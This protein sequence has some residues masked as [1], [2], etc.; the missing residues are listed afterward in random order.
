MFKCGLTLVVGSLVLPSVA[1]WMCV[2]LC[3][4]FAICWLVRA[5]RGAQQHGRQRIAVGCSNRYDTMQMVS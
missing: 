5:R 1:E 2:V 4:A 3:V